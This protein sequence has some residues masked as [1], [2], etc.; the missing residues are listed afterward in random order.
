MVG[1]ECGHKKSKGMQREK[2]PMDSRRW[3]RGAEA[4]ARATCKERRTTITMVSGRRAQSAPL[5]HGSQLTLQT[6]QS[7]ASRWS[8]WST[9]LALSVSSPLALPSLHLHLHLPPSLS[10][11]LSRSLSFC[12]WAMPRYASLAL[13]NSFGFK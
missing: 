8:S 1:I 4:G 2:M 7:V 13:P 11:S 5:H 3:T 6:D 12:L 9:S 10:L